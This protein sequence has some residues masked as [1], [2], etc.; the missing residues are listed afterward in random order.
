MEKLLQEFSYE[1]HS[2]KSLKA[3]EE[4]IRINKSILIVDDDQNVL[5]TI[6]LD[7]YAERYKPTPVNNPFEAIKL[8]KENPEF[9]SL[10]LLDMVMPGK[11]GEQVVREIH[12]ITKM[13]SIPIIILSG[14]TQTY[15]TK[16]LL[17]SMGVT[18]FIEKPYTY[19]ELHN[20]INN[21][22]KQATI[23]LPP[24]RFS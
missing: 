8:I 9:F 2:I 13:Y 5:D 14:H 10:V 16:H 3:L 17:Y 7:I 24:S 22:L 19:N 21:Y 11:N 15:E 1:Y 20:I 6:S 4:H 18:A 23:P 12:T